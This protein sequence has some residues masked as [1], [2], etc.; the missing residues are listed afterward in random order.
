M[1]AYGTIGIDGTVE[2][3]FAKVIRGGMV[4]CGDEFIVLPQP[5]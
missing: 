4:K 2:G 1:N 5:D 3:V